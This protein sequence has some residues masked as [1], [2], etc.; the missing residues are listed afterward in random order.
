M[1]KMVHQTGLLLAP[2]VIV[3]SGAITI[4]GV[5]MLI[6]CAD[7]AKMQSL[8][9]QGWEHMPSY[10]EIGFRAFGKVGLVAVNASLT[11]SQLGFCCSYCV[12]LIQN[13]QESYQAF[14]GM[15]WSL[16]STSCALIIFFVCSPLSWIRRMS[17][18]AVPS[19][20]ANTFTMAIMV[21]VVVICAGNLITTPTLP[22]VKMVNKEGLLV[23]IGMAMSMLEGI[24]MMVP[25]YTQCS[26]NAQRFQAH[27]GVHVIRFVSFLHIFW[28]G[29]LYGLWS[30]DL[31]VCVIQSATGYV[32][33]NSTINV[34][35]LSFCGIPVGCLSSNSNFGAT[36]DSGERQNKYGGQGE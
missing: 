6:D 33:I 5:T 36:F 13:I 8:N 34:S 26:P 14:Y 24:G 17:V 23:G 4:Y 7:E 28:L 32:E 31:H 2:V 29:C 19:F 22:D 15:A 35:I 30:G 1:P 9:P 3:V 25:A 12:L 21:L 20:S 16:S 27:G 10:G 18:F 11:L